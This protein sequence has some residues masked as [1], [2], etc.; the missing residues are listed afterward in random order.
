MLANDPSRERVLVSDLVSALGER[1]VAAFIL[2]FALPNV[3]PVA[4]VAAAL[5]LRTFG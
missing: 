5:L 1:A 2:L 4:K 3:L